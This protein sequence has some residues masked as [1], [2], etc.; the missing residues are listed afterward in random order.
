[1]TG[2]AEHR[3]DRQRQS[4]VLGRARLACGVTDHHPITA[5]GLNHRRADQT[6]DRDRQDRHNHQQLVHLHVLVGSHH[7]VFGFGLN[8]NPPHVAPNHS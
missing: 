8:G 7:S 6:G 4:D 1:M 2:F 5:V 3:L